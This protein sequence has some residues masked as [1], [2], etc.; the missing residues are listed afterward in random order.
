LDA[1]APA[2]PRGI[3]LFYENY[4]NFHPYTRWCVP[5]PFPF[6]GRGYE[7]LTL[8]SV[9]SLKKCQ[10]SEMNFC[11]NMKARCWNPS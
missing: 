5:P 8:G 7:Y 1:Y 4:V 10:N 2:T 9:S 6:L 3:L 11:E